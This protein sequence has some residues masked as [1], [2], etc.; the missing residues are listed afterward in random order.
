M[1]AQAEQ[2]SATAEQRIKATVEDEKA[3]D[4]GGRGA[5]DYGCHEPRAEAIAAVR[6]GTGDR[7]G[8]AQAGGLG[9]DG[10][11]AGAGFCAAA[12]RRRVEEG[13]ELMASS[14]PRYARAFAEVASRPAGCGRGR[15]ADARLCG[16]AGGQQRAAR[17]PGKPLDRDGRKLKV[18]DAIAARIGMFPPGAE[19]HCGDSGA[20]SPG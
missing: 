2:D 5:G 6:G 16:D 7:A 1:R 20:P 3:E 4:S 14:A 19:L 18:L 8:G 17:G 12:D 11:A 9:G 15:A 13:T 10:P